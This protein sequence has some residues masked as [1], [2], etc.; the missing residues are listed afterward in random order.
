MTLAEK[1]AALRGERKLSQGDLAERLEVSRQSVSKWE[2]GQAIPE[3]DKIIKLADLFGVSVDELVRDGD[4]PQ[5]Q[6]QPQ[7]EAE[8]RIVSVR[9]WLSKIQIAGAVL[10]VLGLLNAAWG[11]V[12]SYPI[13]MLLSSL[14]VVISLPFL[15]CRKHPFLAAGWVAVALSLVFLNPY[16]SVTPLG[17]LGGIQLM[18]QIFQVPGLNTSALQFGAAI[19]IL[20]GG[21][22][23]I[24]TVL[25]VRLALS[26]WRARRADRAAA[27]EHPGP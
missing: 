11:A 7:P 25:T 5:P 18:A 22:A 10:L 21:L 20:R 16:T 19:A 17:L 13:W 2:T 27:P 6:P 26:R 8:K 3:L 1:I 12:T 4:A 14:V 24:L 9:P 23:L 15:L